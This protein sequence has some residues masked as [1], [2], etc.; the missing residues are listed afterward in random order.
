MVRTRSSL[1]LKSMLFAVVL[2]AF[3]GQTLASLV[4]SQQSPT[5]NVQGCV[6]DASLG[7]LT[8]KGANFQKGAAVTLRSAAGQ[9]RYGGV[10]VKS[11]AKIVVNEVAESDLA[12]GVDV[13]VVNPDG[14]TVSAHVDVAAQDDGRLTD[15]DVKQIIAQAAAQAN[16][17]GLKVTIAVSDKEGNIL[18]VFVMS[19]ARGDTTVT[20][21]TR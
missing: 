15:A 19:G 6:F 17:S 13:T 3:T 20:V 9:V 4:Q 14:S 5:I 11:A 8:I 12:G 21:P 18:G 10:K 2:L 1:K 7:R 16:A